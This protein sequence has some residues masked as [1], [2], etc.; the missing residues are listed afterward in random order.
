LFFTVQKNAFIPHGHRAS[1]M[2]R[3]LLWL[4]VSA[5]SVGAQDSNRIGARSYWGYTGLWVEKYHMYQVKVKWDHVVDDDGRLGIPVNTLY[6]WPYDWHRFAVA[7]LFWLCRRPFDPWFA[8]IVTV[9][10][11]RIP[12]F[13]GWTPGRIALDTH[14]IA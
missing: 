5:F 14:G 10:Y 9:E 12:A 2:F 6:G 4:A 8:M 1:T 11:A 13:P 3:L 7:P